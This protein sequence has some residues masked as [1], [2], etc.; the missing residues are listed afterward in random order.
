[1]PQEIIKLK[2]FKAPKPH[3]YGAKS[4]V[5]DGISFPSRKE[6]NRYAELKLLARAGVI[7]NLECQIPYE[8]EV[9]GLHVCRYIADFRYWHNE[10]GRTVVEDAKGFV[11]DVFRLKKKLMRAVYGIEI[12]EVR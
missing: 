6:G 2:D 9:N 7:S 3:K 8:I 11:T 4:C 12:I 1:M 5:I 10:Q